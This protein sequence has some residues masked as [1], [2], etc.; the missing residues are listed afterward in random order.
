[1]P[2]HIV[3]QM[4]ADSAPAQQLFLLFHGVGSIP[5]SLFPLGKLLAARFPAAAVVCVASPE[6]SDRGGGRQWFSV[7]G[8][9]EENRPGRVA[10]AMDRFVGVVRDWQTRTGCSSAQTALV[11]FSQGAIM[12][13]ESTQ[14]DGESLAG[15]VVALAGRFAAGVRV[16]A[17]STTVHFVHGE[18]DPVIAC[19]YAEAG[20]SALN[21]LGGDATVDLLPGGGHSV[22]GVVGQV[23]ISRLVGYVPKRVW[24]EAVR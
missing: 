3:V 18:D 24:E 14:L 13:L 12:A 16:A 21:G 15:R 6:A 11:G 22:D 10:A 5:E 19:G 17:G 1:M 23:V 2:E 20:A 8:V 4:P 7:R 9:T